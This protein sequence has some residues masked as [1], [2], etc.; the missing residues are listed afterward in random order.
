VSNLAISGWS[1]IL[2][3]LMS[4]HA[5][6]N[7]CLTPY[8]RYS[9]VTLSTSGRSSADVLKDISSFTNGQCSSVDTLS[10]FSDQLQVTSID[11][12]SQ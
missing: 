4:Q 6:A 7:Y 3:L 1:I 12:E 10:M 11:I 9:H 5:A 2:S 8:E